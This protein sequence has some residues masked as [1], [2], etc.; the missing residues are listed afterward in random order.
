MTKAARS[1]RKNA[2][3]TAILID[4]LDTGGFNSSV[5]PW[6]ELDDQSLAVM[7]VHRLSTP[8]FSALRK[9]KSGR[10]HLFAE[11]DAGGLQ[12]ASAMGLVEQGN[13]VR[14]AK[15]PR[16]ALCAS[17]LPASEGAHLVHHRSRRRT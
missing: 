17:A 6:L 10:S 16:P 1:L 9:S 5:F 11:P 2:C 3:T 13:W 7:Q 8:E 14:F 4:E 15:T 12:S